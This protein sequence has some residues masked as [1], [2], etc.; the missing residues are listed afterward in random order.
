MADV[1]HAQEGNPAKLG[2]VLSSRSPTPTSHPSPS[3]SAATPLN[4]SPNTTSTYSTRSPPGA[5]C[6]RPLARGRDGCQR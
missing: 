3:P 5:D 2:R 6:P 4:T 1:N